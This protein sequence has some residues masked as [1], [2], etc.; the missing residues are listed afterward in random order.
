MIRSGLYA[1][2]F[3]AVTAAMLLLGSPLLLGPRSWAMAALKLHGR[4]CV[5]LL[6]IVCGTRLELRGHEKLPSGA[7]LVA[8]KHQS[9]WD[10]FAL[11]SMMR[12]PAMVMKRELLWIP[13]YGWF[14]AKFGMIFVRRDAGASALRQ[15]AR[16]A[17]NRANAGREIVIFPEGTR[18]PP[19]A[20]PDYKSGVL[21]LYSALGIPCAPVALNSGL[22]WPRRSL[23]RYPG[24][25]IVEFLDPI[26][27][28]LERK[29]FLQRLQSAIEGASDRLI[30]EAA[31]SDMPPP[32]AADV[33]RRLKI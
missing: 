20:P 14:S 4:V 16:D 15:M 25:I 8:A 23:R 18:R 9:A 26:P 2:L 22:Y 5:S 10:T 27:A 12:D 13:L 24:T 3:Y 30:A 32:I 11:V 21:F 6:R 29:E 17:Q 1:I 28:G 33:A 31:K 19:G 7:V